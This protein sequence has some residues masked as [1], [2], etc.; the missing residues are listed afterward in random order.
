MAVYFPVQYALLPVVFFGSLGLQFLF[1]SCLG[2]GFTW[3][4]AFACIFFQLF[5]RHFAKKNEK[6]ENLPK[7]QK[8]GPL[9]SLLLSRLQQAAEVGGCGSFG[10]N[11]AL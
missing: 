7:N 3:L 6:S 4:P 9:G 10:R 1:E 5:F 8:N 11:Q 2:F